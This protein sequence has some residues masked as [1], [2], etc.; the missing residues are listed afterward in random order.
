MRVKSLDDVTNPAG[1]V[2]LL[3]CD[4]TDEPGGCFMVK[5]KHSLAVVIRGDNYSGP[6]CV[7]LPSFRMCTYLN[8]FCIVSDG[9]SQ[10]LRSCMRFDENIREFFL[11]LSGRNRVNENVFLTV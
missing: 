2:K 7:L 10:N 4:V 8:V 11:K 5:G 6:C 3:P 9:E 1:A